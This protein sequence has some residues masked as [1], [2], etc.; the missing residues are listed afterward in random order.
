MLIAQISDLHVNAPGAEGPAGT[1]AIAAADALVA[2]VGAMEPAPD[3]I[4]ATG[5]LAATTGLAD[6]YDA[7]RTAL[8]PLR[9][10]IYLIPGNHD[11]R[12]SLRNA[13]SDHDYLPGTGYLHYAIDAWPVRLVGLDTVIPGEPGGIMDHTQLDWLDTCL[14]AQPD[15]PTILFMHHPPFR[16]GIA[17]MDGMRCRNGEA[18]E[19]VVSRH[20]QII[21]VLCGHVHR[22][23][24]R[25]WGGTLAMIAPSSLVQLSLS[26]GNAAEPSY[27]HEPPALLLHDWDGDALTSH[28]V[29]VGNY[30]RADAG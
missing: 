30:R 1:D 16:S 19:A 26:L 22:P 10:P 3:V 9:Q 29:T 27:I 12:D 25:L 2:F 21:R 20:P 24:Q 4:L 5:D 14:Q 18:L 13:F 17:A 11:N 15:K 23:I 6:E 8:T 28:V 7:L